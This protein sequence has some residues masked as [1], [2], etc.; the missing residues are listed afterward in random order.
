MKSNTLGAALAALALSALSANAWNVSGVVS[1]P[2][3]NSAAGIVVFV[4]GQPGLSTTTTGNGAFLIELPATPASYTLCVDA[5]TLPTGASVSGCVTINLDNFNQ[6]VSQNFTLS[7]PFCTPPEHVGKCWLTGGGT[8]GKA[9][10]APRFSYGGVVNPGCSPTAAGGGNW[11]VVDHLNH[12]HFKGQFI[13]VISCDGSSD[14]APKVTVNTIDFMGTGIISGTDGNP[15]PTTAVCFVGH[16]E[17]HGEPGHGKDSLYLDV[18][19]CSSDA[20]FLLISSDQSDPSDV[21][22]VTVSTGNLQIHTSSCGK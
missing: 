15:M 11:N 22:P 10:G 14:K 4:Q 19:D 18:F 3:G 8:I 13:T 16:A 2:N 1:C 6:F 17:D 7:G 5:S 21:A 20:T 12:L 9:K